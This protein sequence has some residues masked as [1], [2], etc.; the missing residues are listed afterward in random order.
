MLF[1]RERRLCL[2]SHPEQPSFLALPKTFDLLRSMQL[3]RPLRV[4][5]NATIG[6]PSHSSPLLKARGA[7]VSSF[8][9]VGTITARVGTSL[10][11]LAGDP[12][13]GFSSVQSDIRTIFV[14][15]ALMLIDGWNC[16]QSF[17]ANV[18]FQ[19][20]LFIVLTFVICFFSTFLL[21]NNFN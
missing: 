3:Q 20:S 10:H 12:G 2:S 11:A 9:V 5:A 8:T 15:C 17:F 6:A 18:F 1:W 13:A 14:V 21:D 19:L 4:C 16:F 7:L